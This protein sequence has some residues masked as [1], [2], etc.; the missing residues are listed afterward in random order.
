MNRRE[1]LQTL[2]AILGSVSVPRSSSAHATKVASPTRQA[3]AQGATQPKPVSPQL[4]NLLDY[5]GAAQLRLS[6]MAFDYVAEGAADEVT[7]G[8]NRDCLSAIRLNPRV[9]ADVSRLNTQIDLLGQ[10]LDFPILLAPAAFHKLM[11]PE[12]E[13]AT[14]RGASAAGAVLVASSVSTTSIEE[15]AKSTRG[16]LWF[17]LYVQRDRGFTR[18][19]VQRAEASGCR[20]LCVTV[21]SPVPGTRNREMRDA[22]HLLPGMTLANFRGLQTPRDDESQMSAAVR[23]IYNVLMDPKLTWDGIDAIRSYAKVPVVLKGI[24]NPEDARLAVAHGVDGVL[25]SNHGGRQLDTVPATIE[26]LPRVV[27]SV[28][29]RIPVLM[30]GGIR[31]GTDV[32]KALAL[33]ARAVLIGRPYLW[34]LAVDGAAGVEQVIH[35]L[36]R[37][38]LTAMALCGKSTISQIGRDLIWQDH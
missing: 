22:F 2:A 12:G 11:D 23:E 35:I 18:E 38:F 33:G 25:V 31:R 34:G 29:G 1:I 3:P 26:A 9:L 6:K 15:I 4:A 37:E 14:A 10:K 8:R 30:D 16:P 28:G 13:I 24:L 36:R 27:E 19:L 7:L 17:Q 5:E 32:I 21:D 20:A